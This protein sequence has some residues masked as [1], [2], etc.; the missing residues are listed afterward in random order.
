[1]IYQPKRA[2]LVLTCRY[3]QTPSLAQRATLLICRAAMFRDLLLRF[4]ELCR[5]LVTFFSTS[6]V[7]DR[8][9]LVFVCKST[10]NI[11]PFQSF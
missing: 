4:G 3:L 6:T 1:M 2:A 8:H 7:R 10:L 5:I 9:M 11:T